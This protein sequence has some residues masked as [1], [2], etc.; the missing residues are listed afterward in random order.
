MKK[1]FE[2][3]RNIL[4]AVPEDGKVY[5]CIDHAGKKLYDSIIVEGRGT[6]ITEKDKV[7]TVFDYYQ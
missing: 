2:T 1:L 5:Q 3:D 4:I 7:R 6:I